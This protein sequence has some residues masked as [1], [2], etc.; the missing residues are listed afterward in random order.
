M[1][2][3]IE[4]REGLKDTVNEAHLDLIDKFT[5]VLRFAVQ[6]NAVASCINCSQFDE[7]MEICRKFKQRPP[8]RVIALSCGEDYEDEND[9]PF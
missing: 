3:K 5:D 2:I 7:K 1:S 9:I 6:N 4:L 8:A